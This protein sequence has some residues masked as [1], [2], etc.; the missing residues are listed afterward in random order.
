MILDLFP[1]ALDVDVYGAGVADVFVAP[2]VIQQ[3]LSGEYL[4][5]R[6]R[7]EIEQL[8]LLGRH[9]HRVSHI[10]DRVVGQVDGEVRVFHEFACL[11]RRGRRAGW[12]VP[13][14]HGFYPGHQLFRVK[15]FDHVIVGAQLQ[16][17]HLVKGL[18]LG[19]QHDDGYLAFGA[20]LPADLI[21]VHAGQHQIQ[22]YQIRCKA[23]K[24]LQRFLAVVGN[25]GVVALFVQV[26]GDQL[27]DIH[28]V[29]YN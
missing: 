29:I 20:K 23:F 16:S 11:G 21:A 19:G 8:Q 26:E 10:E 13:A 14:Q 4:I 2:D 18:A 22:Q 5:G 25:L 6:G 15:G 17:Q 27:C 12:L 28:V 7:Q 1:E 24:G 3:L 9:F